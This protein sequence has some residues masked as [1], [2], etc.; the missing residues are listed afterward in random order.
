MAR[1]FTLGAPE[2][3]YDLVTR[4][5][6]LIFPVYGL[7]QETIAKFVVYGHAWTTHRRECI[8]AARA[9]VARE[10]EGDGEP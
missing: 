10:L 4:V 8:E 1:S 6:H 9:C 7:S 2:E 5:W 3:N